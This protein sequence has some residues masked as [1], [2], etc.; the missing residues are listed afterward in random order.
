MIELSTRLVIIGMNNP[1]SD[2]PE[3]ALWTQPSG[4]TGNLLW[5]MATRHTGISESEW[6]SITDRRNLCIGP[7]DRGDACRRAGEWFEELRGRTVIWLGVDVMCAFRGP[8]TT[9]PY[10][11]PPFHIGL[12]PALMWNETEDWFEVPHPSGLNRWYNNDGNRAAVE[13][14]LADILW[15]MGYKRTAESGGAPESTVLLSTDGSPGVEDRQ[16]TEPGGGSSSSWRQ[17]DLF[18]STDI[19]CVS[20]NLED[21]DRS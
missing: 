1:A 8:T 12:Q 3:H 18:G 11:R 7:W 21:G 4:C 20:S 9:L 14:R 10:W 19:S 6:L 5:R 15:E 13:I 16:E 2:R 17:T